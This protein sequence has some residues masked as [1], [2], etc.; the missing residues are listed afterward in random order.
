MSVEDKKIR[1]NPLSVWYKIGVYR[2]TIL[3]FLYFVVEYKLIPNIP[4]LKVSPFSR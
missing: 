1:Y 2:L 4:V 3:I